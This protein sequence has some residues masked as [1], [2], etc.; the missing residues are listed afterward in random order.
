MLS[1][2]AASLLLL[3]P[4]CVWVSSLTS[5]FPILSCLILQMF[6]GGLLKALDAQGDE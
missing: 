1:L 3:M 2:V 5:I 6:I 4:L